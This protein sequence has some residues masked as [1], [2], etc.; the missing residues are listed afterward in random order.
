LRRVLLDTSVVIA[1]AHGRVPLSSLPAEGAISIVTL[2]ELHHGVLAATDER[3]PG[4]LLTLDLV[5]RNFEAIP[6]DERVAP[7]FGQLMA[8]ARRASG[9]CPGVADA[10]IAATAIAHK[11]PIFTCDRDFEAFQGVDLVFV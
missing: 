2:C 4:R 7:R 6:V 3:R 5:Q 8:A 10:L 11:L 1:G 9:G